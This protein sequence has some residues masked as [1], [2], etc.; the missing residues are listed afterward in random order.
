MANQS[1]GKERGA[2]SVDLNQQAITAV[3][4]VPEASPMSARNFPPSFWNSNYQP[5]AATVTS[6]H[7]T[8]AELYGDPY[9]HHHSAATA[10]ADPWHSHYQQYSAAAAHHHHRYL[11]PPV[12]LG[13]NTY[14]SYIPFYRKSRSGMPTSVLNI[15]YGGEKMF[16][17]HLTLNWTSTL[18]CWY[19]G[20]S[21]VTNHSCEFLWRHE[22]L[23]FYSIYFVNTWYIKPIFLL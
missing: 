16:R 15:G 20:M 6:H 22:S 21:M 13:F 4:F 19:Y 11:W 7:P 2:T 8:T 1:N 14:Q 5:S 12:F 9:H 18:A 3:H 17:L 23:G 10:S